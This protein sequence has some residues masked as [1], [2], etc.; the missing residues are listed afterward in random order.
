MVKIQNNK[1]IYGDI[2]KWVTE[3]I[4]QEKMI[5]YLWGKNPH[6]NDSIFD[7]IDWKAVEGCMKKLARASGSK[8]TNTLKLVHGWQNDGQQKEL[9]YEDSDDTLC[10]AGCGEIE[11][12]MYLFSA[13][14][15]TYRLVT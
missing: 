14:L 4:T 6:W 2:Q 9:F 8:V 7:S 13:K 1:L 10:P 12:R 5:K 3:A 15:N 11:S